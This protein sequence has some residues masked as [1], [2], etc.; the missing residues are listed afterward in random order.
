MKLKTTLVILAVSV[1][2]L[3]AVSSARAAIALDRTRVIFPG[4]ENSV[5]LSVSNENPQLPYLA[6]SWIENAQG[7][8]VSG[9]MVIL[10]PVQRVEAGA[11]TAVKI[12]STGA[13]NALPQD[14]ETLF[15]FNLREIPPRSSKSNALQIA[16]QT[17]IKLF[18]RPAG[19]LKPASATPWQNDLTLVRQGDKYSVHNPTPYYVTISEAM[20]KGSHPVDKFAAVM[21]APKSD[22]SLGVNAATLGGSPELTYINDYGGRQTLTFSCQGAGCK[23]INNRTGS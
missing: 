11:K 7:E 5:S 9:P 6:Q 20:A 13:M 12:Q 15:Y 23:V 8:K 10:P 19:L 17:K 18:Y 4:N 1:S 22:A 14:R 16:L 3:T 2:T 21:V